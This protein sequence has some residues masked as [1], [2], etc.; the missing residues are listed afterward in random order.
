MRGRQS[1]HR[2][3]VFAGD[4]VQHPQRN[5]RTLQL[6]EMIEAS[7]HECKILRLGDQLVDGRRLSAEK[8]EGLIA[9]IMWASNRVPAASVARMVPHQNREELDRVIV[10]FDQ[11][12]GLWQHE[13][14]MERV[15]NAVERILFSQ[16]FSPG[17]A[18]ESS[19]VGMHESSHPFEKPRPSSTRR[20]AIVFR[21]RHSPGGGRRLGHLIDCC[22]H[23]S[24]VSSSAGKRPLVLS[25]VSMKYFI[26]D[27]LSSCIVSTRC[28][29][30]RALAVT[31]RR[32]V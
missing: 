24:S 10:R 4:L 5:D 31:R 29:P 28:S 12:P 3:H 15:L 22:R 30:E 2:R 9:R 19:P 18:V 7:D 21:S 11:L 25:W 8:G 32:G 17:Q 26:G 27:L 1:E 14:R 23:C 6:P 16:P 20:G 13:E